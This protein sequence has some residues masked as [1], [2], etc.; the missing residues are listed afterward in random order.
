M[1][2]TFSELENLIASC[3]DLARVTAWQT[4]L[5]TDE[6]E[7]LK[8]A[9]PNLEIGCTLHLIAKHYIRTDATVFSTLHGSCGEHSTKQLRGLQYCTNLMALDIG[10]NAL[11]D[12]SFLEQLPNLRV[13]ILA[14]NQIRDISVLSKLKN[15]EYIELFSNDLRDISPLAELPHLIDLNLAYNGNV[16][17]L[18]PLKALKTLKRLWISR[19]RGYLDKD[20]IASL[21]EA[22][23]DTTIMTGGHPT[24]KGW[25]D[26]HPHYQVI[27]NMF[28]G[29]TYIPFE[30]SYPA[31]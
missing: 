4:I 22:L 23:P 26:D 31:E 13:L 3:P 6:Y 1:S 12:I 14:G 5:E 17:S 30:D 10:H 8:A 25:R 15:L 20:L 18:E 28:R 27:Y 29:D 24:A 7:S 11:T 19:T 21:Q 2:L 9:W 16:K